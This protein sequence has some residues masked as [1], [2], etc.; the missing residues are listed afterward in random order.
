MWTIQELVKSATEN[1]TETEDGRWVPSRPFKGDDLL[2]RF[3]DAWA[4]LT[5]KADAVEWE[6]Q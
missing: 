2:T 6:G 3:K 1:A 5:G 4:V